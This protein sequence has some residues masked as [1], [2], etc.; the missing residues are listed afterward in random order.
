MRP[1]RAPEGLSARG[2]S[3]ERE[4]GI[5]DKGGE[6]E[7]RKPQGPRACE[8]AVDAERAGEETQGNGAGVAEEDAR[9]RKVMHE[10]AQAR[11]GDGR[12]GPGKRRL[13]GRRRRGRQGAESY[14]GHAARQAVAAIHEVEEVRHPHDRQDRQRG[15]DSAKAALSQEFRGGRGDCENRHGR[16]REVGRQANLDRQASHVVGKRNQGQREGAAE[17]HEHRLVGKDRGDGQCA[18]H[19]AQP[20][21]ARSRGGVERAFVRVVREACGPS[22]SA[23]HLDREPRHECGQDQGAQPLERH[24][25]PR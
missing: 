16:G 2:A 4:R 19:H 1:M 7:Q 6:N 23:Q 25:P 12:A 14:R 10:K 9:G 13:P 18:H 3:H 22:R 8:G 20:P 5:V 21:N 17:H 15:F 24:V 11:R